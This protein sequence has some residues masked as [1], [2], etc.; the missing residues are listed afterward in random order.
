MSPKKCCDDKPNITTKCCG[1]KSPDCCIQF[2]CVTG[3]TGPQGIQGPTGIT[4]PRGVDGT[5]THTG[6]TG[7]TGIQ[8]PIGP[9]GIPGIATNTGPTG[10]TG[11]SVQFI[12]N[13]V[14]YQ[15]IQQQSFALIN[16]FTE[17]GNG[18][19]GKVNAVASNNSKV[20]VGG[21]FTK[22]V[23][24]TLVLNN[25]AVFDKLTQQWSA[26]DT[27]VNGEVKALI[28]DPAS[29]NL[30]VAGCFSKAGSV[31]TFNFA[32][33]NVNSFQ[34]TTIDGGIGCQ[35]D[36]VN[37]IDY[38]DGVVYATGS[39][40]KASH[41]R[42]NNVV[43]SKCGKWVTLMKC[44]EDG[45]LGVGYSI[46]HDSSKNATYVGGSYS[47]VLFQNKLRD[48]FNNISCWTKHK[49][50]SFGSGLGECD[51]DSVN[52]LLLTTDSLYAG[53]NF[54][55]PFKYIARWVFATRSWLG[56]GS[57]V[58]GPVNALTDF[59]STLYVGGD[60]NRTAGLFA[61]KLATYDTLTTQWA[62]V[63][64]WVPNGPVNAI[65]LSS[66]NSIEVGGS[67]SMW[68]EE[69]VLSIVNIRINALISVTLYSDVVNYLN[70]LNSGIITLT[71][72]IPSVFNGNSF[73]DFPVDCFD[74][75]RNGQVIYRGAIDTNPR[76]MISTTWGNVNGD[77]YN[78]Y[79]ELARPA[80]FGKVIVM[81]SY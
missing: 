74:L 54:T 10:P 81:A 68:G 45:I 2:K 15:E 44:S 65:A 73:T 20:Y 55:K 13:N 11:N 58:D 30:Y 38:K 9:I 75:K 79:S 46:V 33:Y 28:Y 12:V 48:G 39:F 56:L 23:N 61:S 26:L 80:I 57:G 64:V 78:M 52:V 69:S 63:T 50:Y 42:V 36:C 27:G 72:L 25:I 5:A 7:T 18:L 21:L 62:P 1:D 67:Y 16:I 76:E 77:T 22:E 37:A 43:K 17:Y 40:I 4:G 35:G 19:N 66:D 70:T 34:W 41:K 51:N 60:F 24:K 6:P 71:T 47:R 59:G 49:V 32:V 53:G 14:V 8:G 29:G 3:P 31:R